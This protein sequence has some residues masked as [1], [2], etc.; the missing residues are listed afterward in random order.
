MAKKFKED[1]ERE[2]RMT[3]DII[4]DCYNEQE[5]AMEW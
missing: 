4:V 2:D 5:Q 3:H 1:P